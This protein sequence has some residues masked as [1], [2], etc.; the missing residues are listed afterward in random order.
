MTGSKPQ[1]FTPDSSG[2]TSPE[3]AASD[4]EALSGHAPDV[5]GGR[6]PAVRSEL[7]ATWSQLVAGEIDQASSHREQLIEVIRRQTGEPPAEIS[8]RINHIERDV[9]AR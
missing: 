6:W 8:R 2:R 1:R 3:G 4:A 7:C 9:A 5:W